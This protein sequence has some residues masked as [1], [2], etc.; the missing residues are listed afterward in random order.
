MPCRHFVK[1]LLYFWN[2]PLQKIDRII[3]QEMVFS[4]LPPLSVDRRGRYFGK[5]RE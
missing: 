4:V 5:V 2:E 1:P 3:G